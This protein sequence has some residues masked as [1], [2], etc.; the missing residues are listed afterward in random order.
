MPGDVPS[1]LV[2]LLEHAHLP[3]H[4]IAQHELV[5]ARHKLPGFVPLIHAHDI[6]FAHDVVAGARLTVDG[7]REHVHSGAALL[8]PARGHGD[9]AVYAVAAFDRAHEQPF[10]HED[11]P[12]AP[13][14]D[15][16]RK[17]L[18]EYG[19]SQGFRRGKDK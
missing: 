18:D 2:V 11:A 9:A 19:D 17:A 12:V 5:D 3:G 14:V 4:D 16:G 6:A 10:L 15:C 7:H 8:A 1:E 13:H